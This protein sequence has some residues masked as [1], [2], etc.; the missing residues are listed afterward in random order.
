MLRFCSWFIRSFPEE[1]VSE[2]VL[3][4]YFQKMR[5]DKKDTSG[6]DQLLQAQNFCSGTLGLS[7]PVS[8]LRSARVT[9]LAHQCL[10]A[11]ETT[12]QA[13]PLTK[14]QVLWLENLARNAE[15]PYEKLLASSF[16]LTLYARARHSDVRRATRILLDA[17]TDFI[18]GFVELVVVD[19]KQSS[20]A[21]C[22]GARGGHC[23]QTVGVSLAG[24]QEALETGSRGGHH[25]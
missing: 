18:Q 4:L 16:P 20:H 5:K 12:K 7:V 15:S 25:Q 23:R 2:P 8:D 17:G 24:Q 22:R 1:A 19:P 14:E 13:Q 3:F 6:P 10:R 21:S 11:Q 9:G